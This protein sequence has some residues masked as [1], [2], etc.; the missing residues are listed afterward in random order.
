M[1]FNE[2][3]FNYAKGHAAVDLKNA[4]SALEAGNFKLAKLALKGARPFVK[5]MKDETLLEGAT[6]AAL[7]KLAEFAA[8]YEAAEMIVEKSAI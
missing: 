1:R 8:R 4:E 5:T 2:V 6:R 3:H 7:D